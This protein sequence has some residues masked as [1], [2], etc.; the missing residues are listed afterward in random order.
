[1]ANVTPFSPSL[2]N[3]CSFRDSNRKRLSPSHKGLNWRLVLLRGQ[4]NRAEKGQSGPLLKG[5]RISR[6]Q[7]MNVDRKMRER[8]RKAKSDA[9]RFR[10]LEWR[11]MKRG[12]IPIPNTT[13]GIEFVGVRE[14]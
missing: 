12:Q 3:F 8:E 2:Q 11:R 1:M 14:E 10:K 6:R 5:S 9:K 7:A 13:A 4:K